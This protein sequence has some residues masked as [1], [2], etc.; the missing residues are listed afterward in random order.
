MKKLLLLTTIFTT[1]FTTAFTT[2]GPYGVN[3]VS[4]GPERSFIG[5]GRKEIKTSLVKLKE[6]GATN[7]R[8][9]TSTDWVKAPSA[10]NGVFKNAIMAKAMG[11]EVTL[12]VNPE[13][14]KHP[15]NDQ[16]VKDYFTKLLA[17]PGLKSAVAYWEIGNEVDANQ[18]WIG[19]DY[20]GFIKAVVIPASSVLR[21]AGVKIIG[22]SP[23]WNPQTVVLGIQK[24]DLLKYVDFV[25][26]HG[27]RPDA[28]TLQA[29]LDI[30]WKASAPKKIA[31]TEWTCRGNLWDDP[32]RAAHG[33]KSKVRRPTDVEAQAWAKCI[34]T[35]WPVIKAHPGVELAHYFAD[36]ETKDMAGRDGIFY[37][38]DNSP[39]EPFY[40][41]FKNAK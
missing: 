14:G 22:P 17:I 4:F 31:I 8:L 9:W 15:A 34:A 21:P 37:Q 19:G 32:Y 6:M 13:G 33:D 1:I 20:L 18:Y 7:I 38:I 2:A 5:Q 24:G 39:H 10:T 3:M 26:W 23:T 36:L 12:I 27:Y 30:I 25:A 41:V 40:S 11:F 35:F 29:N 28:K 16:Q